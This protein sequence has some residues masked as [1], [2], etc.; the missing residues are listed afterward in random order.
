MFSYIQDQLFALHVDIL[1]I[2][3]YKTSHFINIFCKTKHI[4]FK[5]F[6]FLQNPSSFIKKKIYK[7]STLFR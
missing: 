5:N 6:F 2:F 4:S 1:I 3:F 7:E